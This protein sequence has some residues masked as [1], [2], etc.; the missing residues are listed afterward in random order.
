[1]PLDL[2]NLDD[3]TYDDLMA[4]ALRL[5]PLYAPEWTNHNPSDPG[6]T[7]IELFAYLSEQLIYR[8]N[9][10][11]DAARWQFIKLL[12]GSEWLKQQVAKYDNYQEVLDLETELRKAVTQV[13]ERYRAVTCQDYEELALEA[14]KQVARARCVARRN[15]VSE[16]PSGRE[17]DSPGH[18]SLIVVPKNAPVSP[19]QSL[20]ESVRKFLEPRRLLATRLSVVGPRY[21]DVS[22]QLRVYLKD[23]AQVNKFF[24]RDVFNIESQ[25]LEEPTAGTV[26]PTAGT[27]LQTLRQRLIQFF[28]PLKGGPAGTGWPFG[29][30]IFLSELYELLED[31]PGVDYIS[32]IEQAEKTPTEPAEKTPELFALAAGSLAL[33]SGRRVPDSSSNFVGIELKPDE[34]VR[35]QLPHYRI[36]PDGNWIDLVHPSS[37]IE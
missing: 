22:I 36:S 11:T 34:L 32:P 14:D 31:I 3:R 37:G 19:E 1:M 18:V 29:R 33:D 8:Q 12:N 20:L 17:Q 7:L 6:I 26:D 23:N 9:R 30:N 13:R 15:L 16:N 21:V 25:P 28:H 2:P 27:I 24:T 35:F 4:E 5:I 10:I